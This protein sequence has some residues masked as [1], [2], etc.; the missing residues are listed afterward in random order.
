MPSQQTVVLPEDV[1]RAAVLAGEFLPSDGPLPGA[2]D[3]ADFGDWLMTALA[4]RQDLIP[5]IRA[6]LESTAALGARE[7]LGTLAATHPT[8][9]AALTTIIAGAYFMH[10]G[11]RAALGYPGQVPRRVH[12]DVDEYAS[13]LET[14]FDR[15]DR[16]RAAPD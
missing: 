15:G 2:A 16:Y 12:S 10:P 4:T 8:R 13:M 11:V 5:K 9:F 7:A 14:V 1:E 6:A 3:L